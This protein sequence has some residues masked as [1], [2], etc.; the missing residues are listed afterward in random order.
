MAKNENILVVKE[1]RSRSEAELRSLLAS[2]TEELHKMNFKHAL[3]QLQQTHM[4]KL[5][6]R[7]VARLETV[8]KEQSGAKEQQA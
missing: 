6:K 8:L 7:D 2:K 5:L 4:L 3:G 1:L